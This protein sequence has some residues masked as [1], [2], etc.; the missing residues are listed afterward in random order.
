MMYVLSKIWLFASLSA[1]AMQPILFAQS[2]E[3]SHNLGC[4]EGHRVIIPRNPRMGTDGNILAGQ[5]IVRAK[6][7]LDGSTTVRIVEYPRSGTELDSYNSTII[8][9]R[10]Q[11]QTKYSIAQIIKFGSA[12]RLVEIASFC[13]SPS[14]G[15]IFLAF[16]TPST[17]MTEGFAV[18]RY[19]PEV[20]DVRA[21]PMANQ[22]GIVVSKAEPEKVEL[23]SAIGGASPIDCDACKKHYAEQDCNLGQQRV[24]CKQRPG[25]G[26]VLLPDKFMGARIEVR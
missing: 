6:L 15:T 5:A 4:E 20:V 17:G 2:P 26:E 3:P 9:Q 19:S 1:A 21:F 23:W 18:I 8:I 25:P 12:L 10:G 13:A 7:T 24:E 14:E 16:E 22:G 11:E